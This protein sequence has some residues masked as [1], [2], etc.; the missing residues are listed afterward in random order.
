MDNHYTYRFFFVPETIGPITLLANKVIEP[1]KTDFCFVV[2]CVANG[3]K[4]NYKKTYLG[5]HPIDNIVSSIPS[6]NCIDFFPNGSDERQFSSPKIR[7]PTS[8]IMYKMYGNYKEYHTSHDDLEFFNYNRVVDMSRIYLSVLREYE[9]RECYII[10][11]DG[12]EPFLSNKGLY[13][14]NWRLERYGI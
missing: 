9:T 2:T 10:S 11:H 1:E 8:S 3:E 7:I 6:V 14:I 13:R 4:I 5:D 12:C